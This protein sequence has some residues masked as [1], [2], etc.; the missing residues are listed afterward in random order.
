MVRQGDTIDPQIIQK[1]LMTADPF[2]HLWSEYNETLHEVTRFSNGM[3]T[4]ENW[5]ATV[6]AEVFFTNQVIVDT[7]LKTEFF[8]H[9]PGLFTGIG[10]IG[11][12]LGLIIG[13]SEFHPE[14]A[15]GT[16][17]LLVEHVAGAFVVSAV[18]ITCAMIITAFE[19]ISITN[20][21]MEVEELCQKHRWIV[22]LRSWGGIPFTFS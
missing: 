5:R 7:P 11:T 15:L 16:L 10:I 9:L 20:R 17:P 13:L 21:Y 4:V 19:K 14:D 18:A 12:F 8:K 6:P 22:C 3:L 2:K 1:K